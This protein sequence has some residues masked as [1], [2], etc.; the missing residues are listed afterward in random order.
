MIAFDQLP[1]LAREHGGTFTCH[2]DL[3]A[4]CRRGDIGP[5]ARKRIDLSRKQ[6]LDAPYFSLNLR[7][8]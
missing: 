4:D 6:R 2:A 7:Q 5:S 1:H 8:F 3:C